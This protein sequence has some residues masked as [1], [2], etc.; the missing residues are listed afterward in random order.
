MNITTVLIIDIIGV[1]IGSVSIVKMLRINRTL[2]GRIGGTINLV[3]G[4][5]ILN[6]LA[7]FW[8]IIFIRLK[9]LPAPQLDVHHLLMTIGMVLFV[10]AAKKFSTLIQQ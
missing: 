8:T 6:V 1:V 2:G 7:F 3:V 5:V 9:L 4:G 10:F